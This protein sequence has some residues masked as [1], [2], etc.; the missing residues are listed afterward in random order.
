MTAKRSIP[1]KVGIVPVTFH[2]T[3]SFGA[4]DIH[5]IIESSS[6][7]TSRADEVGYMT[8]REEIVSVFQHGEGLERG[9]EAARGAIGRHIAWMIE[10][11]VVTPQKRA[12]HIQADNV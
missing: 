6:Y 11:G 9:I 3:V 12:G 2:I 8:V 1:L 7:L 10:E 4:S 5:R